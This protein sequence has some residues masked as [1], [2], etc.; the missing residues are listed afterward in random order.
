MA[1]DVDEMQAMLDMEQEGTA[2]APKQMSDDDL[3]TVVDAELSHAMGSDSDNNELTR[4]WEN[5]LRYYL[6]E[7]PKGVKP[8]RSALV[9]T[10][11]ADMT[12]QTLA[13][14]MP[15]FKHQDLGE[16]ESLGEDDDDQ[17][18]LESD[19]MNYLFMEKN[20][21]YINTLQAVKD[22]MLQRNGILKC[23]V[24]NK[25][26]VTSERYEGV[27]PFDLPQI[28][29]GDGQSQVEV[30]GQEPVSEAIIEPHPMTGEPILVQPA[31]MN[32]EV[33][34]IRRE[35]RL[36]IEP[37]TPEELRINSDHNSPFL[38]DARFVAHVRPVKR[39]DLIA[40]GYD[41][42]RVM[43]LPAY[44][45][46]GDTFQRARSRS[47]EES[48]HYSADRLTEQVLFEEIYMEVDY[49]GDGLAERRRIMKSGSE[50]FENDYFAK[51]PLSGGTPFI[52]PHRFY[53]LSFY[54]KLKQVQDTKT[55]F[56][57]LT[58][59]NA[60]ALINQ[61][62][63]VTAGEVNMDDLLASRPGGVI[64]EKTPGSVRLE[65]S[66]PLGDTGFKMLNYMDKTRREGSG[67]ALDLGTQENH[68]VANAGAR[69]LDR[70]MTSQEQL[71]SLMAE[72]FA[73]TM[74][75]EMYL[76]AH[77]MTRTFLPQKFQFK[78][79]EQWAEADPAQWKPR[80]RCAISI[81]LSN[82]ERAARYQALGVIRQQQLEALTN[83]QE[84][85]LTDVERVHRTQIDQARAAG[86]PSPEQ[87]WISPQSDQAQ[88][89][90]QA[91]NQQMQQQAAMQQQM[92]EGQ[93]QLM[94]QLEAMRNQTDLMQSRMD[95]VV[96]Q[97]E[98]LRKWY[99]TELKYNADLPIP[100]ETGGDQRTT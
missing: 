76:I 5:G 70:F 72:T 47:S 26:E 90:M 96:D 73:E 88:Q 27:T 84:G 30:I 94:L 14:L 8:G 40:M 68:P 41:Y 78:K 100:G 7:L 43:Q 61:R 59:D 69:G 46:D 67:S 37:V 11:I 95:F 9:S 83:G 80:K 50:I 77:W 18:Q 89:A 32:I 87:Y 35:P 16:F 3:R 92:A 34:I 24:D 31:R 45:T 15:A 52:M 91:K 23:Y 33:K 97:N 85:I 60:E 66:Q 62:K 65:P 75:S 6:G 25:A 86:L 48:E 93:K 12:E 19:A 28:M 56:L 22:G 99:E 53:G 98:Q 10:D 79:K 55:R 38:S 4:A 17:A 54:D 21:G 81:G 57:R 42:D 64:R 49:D 71:T 1:T 13:Q 36:V 29:Q 82:S 63:V 20:K 39:S 58:D 2:E 44:N 51:V 74:I